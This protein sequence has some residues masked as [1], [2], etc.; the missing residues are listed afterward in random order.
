MTKKDVT[1]LRGALEFL[2][3]QSEVLVITG[4]VDPIYEISGIQRSL[5]NGPALL[6]ENIK[7]Y[8]WARDIGNL[9]SRRER[10]A[11]MFDVPSVKE[12]TLKCHEAIKK[13]I[14]PS[15]WNST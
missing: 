5:E 7:G 1:S 10:I 2:K 13:P 8:P 15:R 14:P 12:I 3:E 6:F 9:F 4:E 11:K